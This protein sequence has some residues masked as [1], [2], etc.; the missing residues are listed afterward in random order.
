ME[1]LKFQS[2]DESNIL[3]N[4]EYRK[5][6]KKIYQ[7]SSSDTLEIMVGLEIRIKVNQENLAP[8]PRRNIL[9]KV[10]APIIEKRAIGRN[11]ILN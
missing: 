9:K 4:N 6:D 5:L 7:D 3:T 1:N 11:T 10:S 2:E 8:N